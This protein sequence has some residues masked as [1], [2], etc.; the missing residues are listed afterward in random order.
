M[1]KSGGMLPST[2]GCFL[3]S[4]LAWTWNTTARKRFAT[5]STSQLPNDL[6]RYECVFQTLP[7]V[8]RER[9]SVWCRIECVFQTLPQVFRERRSVWC[10]IECALQTPPQVPRERRSVWCRIECAFQTPPQV[11][12]ERRSVWCRIECVF[13]TLPQVL[14]ERRSAWC[15]IQ[16]LPSST[17]CSVTTSRCLEDLRKWCPSLPTRRGECFNEVLAMKCADAQPSTARRPCAWDLF[18]GQL[19]RQ[20]SRCTEHPPGSH[21]TGHSLCV[22]GDHKVVG[23]YNVTPTVWSRR[24]ENVGPNL[25][26]CHVPSDSKQLNLFSNTS[27][28]SRDR[29]V[30]RLPAWAC[31]DPLWTDVITPVT[32]RALSSDEGADP[33][34]VQQRRRSRERAALLN[35]KTREKWEKNVA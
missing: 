12:R 21:A 18:G 7:Q 28:H 16:S 29:P 8:L 4:H 34:T 9:R 30:N 32:L 19:R 3:W 6:D 27:A 25:L 35:P 24:Q 5:C 15:R 23:R 20:H 14:R 2:S 33:S 17:T 31:V 1:S 22:N 13:Q 11:P 10:R 26:E